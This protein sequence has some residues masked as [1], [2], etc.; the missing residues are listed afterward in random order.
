M[1][2]VN[3]A[4]SN[5]LTDISNRALTSIGKQRITNI[6]TVDD[7]M[8]K[9]CRAAIYDVMAD[10]QGEYHWPE[11]RTI[12][13]GI[14]RDSEIS[15][16]GYPQYTRPPGVITIIGIRSNLEVTGIWWPKAS[17]IEREGLIIVSF[18]IPNDTTSFP[19]TL[20][21]EGIKY[22][23]NPSEWSVLL[24]KRVWSELAA[25]I[26]YELDDDQRAVK[27][28][29]DA[30]K[31]KIQVQTKAF[32]GGGSPVRTPQGNALYQ[33]RFSNGRHMIRGRYRIPGNIH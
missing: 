31:I 12:V 10:A 27:A 25:Q 17:W 11:L 21:L 28:R 6:E 23:V 30:D 33:S 16:E 24:K 18:G 19:E 1:T 14:P 26:A 13:T 15:Y 7:T 9:V 29:G 22:S 8:A 5:T 4:T 2:N 32:A 3:T 20:D